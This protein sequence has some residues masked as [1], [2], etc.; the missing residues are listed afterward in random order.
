MEWCV[1]YPDDPYDRV[2][3]PWTRR[4]SWFDI[5]T[6]TELPNVSTDNPGFQVPS[7]V[8]QTTITPLNDSEDIVFT[9]D[10]KPNHVYPEPEYTL[11]NTPLVQSYY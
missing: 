5:S 1:R 9:I 7:V 2:W 10:A 4:A 3:M 6:K 8:M 11:L